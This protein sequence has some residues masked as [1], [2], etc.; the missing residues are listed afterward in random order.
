[1][2]TGR[3][4]YSKVPQW[5]GTDHPGD[6]IFVQFA[7]RAWLKAVANIPTLLMSQSNPDFIRNIE[8]SLQEVGVE[9]WS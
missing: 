1:M 5:L 4:N 9:R 6:S 2:I 3:H 7:L 8:R